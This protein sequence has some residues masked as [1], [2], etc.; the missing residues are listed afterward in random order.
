[1]SFKNIFIVSVLL[2]TAL[3][4]YVVDTLK[5][6]DYLSSN[7]LTNHEQLERFK[8]PKQPNT[9]QDET[10]EEPLVQTVPVD[11]RQLPDDD[12]LM[13]EQ[14]VAFITARL[15]CASRLAQPQ[16]D[17]QPL[18]GERYELQLNSTA[19]TNNNFTEQ[20]E[21][22]L[23]EV[24]FQYNQ[25][26]NVSTEDV[27]PVVRLQ[28]IFLP[29]DEQ[30]DVSFSRFLKERGI[31]DES[32]QGLYLPG[33]QLAVIKVMSIEQALNTAV[34]EAIH[35]INHVYFGQ[36][37]R[38]INEG[39]AE[40]FESNSST[41]SPELESSK[42]DSETSQSKLPEWIDLSSPYDDLLDFYTLLYSEVDWHTSNNRSL[43]FSGS[44]WF[45][46]LLGA[47][48]G[49]FALSN[50]LQSKFYEPCEQLTAEEVGNALSESYPLFEQDFNYWFEQQ[51]VLM[52]TKHMEN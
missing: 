6:V 29:N 19:F 38:F 39:I 10:I 33:S 18:S 23:D 3:A 20:L 1:M 43:Y 21:S 36:L 24:F 30:N 45:Q 34:H 44:V 48:Q 15:Q 16:V 4:F 26:L 46:F 47:E 11:K 42:I 5:L 35:A 40:Y 27:L 52:K 2:A 9:S 50:I 32:I 37:P 13:S 8:A 17:Y 28:M 51:I 25:W 31:D 49:Q 22:R 41:Y 14:N 7:S 12:F